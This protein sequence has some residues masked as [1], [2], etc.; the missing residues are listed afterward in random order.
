MTSSSP[1][2]SGTLRHSPIRSQGTASFFWQL[3][4]VRFPSV[5]YS[6]SQIVTSWGGFRKR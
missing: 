6:T 3:T 1:C 5:G 2:H 4:A